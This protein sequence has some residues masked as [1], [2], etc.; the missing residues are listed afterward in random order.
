VVGLINRDI[1]DLE[2]ADH[3]LLGDVAGDLLDPRRVGDLPIGRSRLRVS[4]TPSSVLLH[5]DRERHRHLE[6]AILSAQY[7][8]TER[9]KDT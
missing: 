2:S 6:R 1:T 8:Y 4:H 3:L 5:R 9:D 7:S